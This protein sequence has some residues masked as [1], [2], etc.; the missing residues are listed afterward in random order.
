MANHVKF[1]KFP[2]AALFLNDSSLDPTNTYVS[3][4][5]ECSKA[6]A[7]ITSQDPANTLWSLWHICEDDL[8]SAFSSKS[9]L[10]ISGLCR[11]CF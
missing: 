7:S 10:G 8:E 6:E 9:M 5:L 1:L 2:A 11:R 3:L 4:S